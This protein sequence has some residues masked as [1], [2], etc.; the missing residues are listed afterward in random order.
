MIFA[1]RRPL[2]YSPAYIVYISHIPNDKKGN[3]YESVADDS[4]VTLGVSKMLEVISNRIVDLGAAQSRRNVPYYLHRTHDGVK[5]DLTAVTKLL[6][7][8]TKHTLDI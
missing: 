5:A 3:W 4:D 7:L 2:C 8:S 6:L 1:L